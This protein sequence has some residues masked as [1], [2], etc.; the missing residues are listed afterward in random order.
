MGPSCPAVAV[1][2]S[3]QSNLAPWLPVRLAF[4]ASSDTGRDHEEGPVPIGEVS[5]Y[6]D[7]DWLVAHG[8]RMT[9]AQGTVLIEQGGRIDALYV[10]LEGLLDV[11]APGKTR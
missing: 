9:V 2:R 1:T 8:K 11:C 4:R 7:I 3:V 6:P 5:G 10:V